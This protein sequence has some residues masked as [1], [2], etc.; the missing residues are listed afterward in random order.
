MRIDG[1][2]NV[3]PNLTTVIVDDDRKET[4]RDAAGAMVRPTREDTFVPEADHHRMTREF[5]DFARMI[6]NHETAS[7]DQFMQETIEAM[8]IIALAAE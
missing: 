4:V 2:P 5:R 8:K 3:A 7:A 1:K 6:D